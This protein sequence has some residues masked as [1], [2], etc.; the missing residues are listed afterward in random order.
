M[1][2]HRKHESR[3]VGPPDL[4]SSVSKEEFERLPRPTEEDIRRA[5]DKGRAEDGDLCA[6]GCVPTL[7]PAMRFF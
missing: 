4:F 1:N 5:L 6:G 3:Q 2:A 7:D